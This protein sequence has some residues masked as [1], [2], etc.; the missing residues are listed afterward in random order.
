[1]E[2]VRAA[3]AVPPHA[4]LPLQTASAFLPAFARSE[5][6]GRLGLFLPALAPL[7]ARVQQL[8]LQL[9]FSDMSLGPGD[10][11]VLSKALPCLTKLA[12]TLE[13][14]DHVP[15]PDLDARLPMGVLTEAVEHLPHLTSLTASHRPCSPME[16]VVAAAFAQQ[17]A[18]AGKRAGQLV[19]GLGT[20]WRKGEAREAKSLV[21]RLL[22][23]GV[24]GPP[25]VRLDFS[26]QE[27]WEANR[28]WEDGS[29]EE[30][31]DEVVEL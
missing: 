10:F 6:V 31:D 19:M 9:A 21:G 11:E 4:W 12:L 25:A 7:G 26:A 17:Q 15:H 13:R 5:G 18:I 28:G 23:G 8:T 29:I 30:G 2:V 24:M 14:Y 3:M 20:G 27:R 16:V 22:G 1:M